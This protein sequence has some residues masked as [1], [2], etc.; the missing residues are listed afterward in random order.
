MPPVP[1]QFE[2]ALSDQAPASS[3]LDA[4]P[5]RRYAE[6]FQ[7]LIEDN[8]FGSYV[9]D[10]GLRVLHASKTALRGFAS[11]TPFIGRDL[12]EALR[13]VWPEPFAS[14][15]L[16]RFQ[17]T[18]TTGEPYVSRGTVEQRADID[19][20]EAYDWR[21][22]RIPLPDETCG[23]VCY[24]YDFSDRFLWEQRLQRSEARLALVQD[25]ARIGW[26]D[27]NVVSGTLEWSEQ[28]KALFELPPDAVMSYARFLSAIHP[29][30]TAQVDA[31]VRRA[32]KGGAPFDVEMRVLLP[33][34]GVRWVA[35]KGQAYRDDSGRTARMSG[36]ALD[37]T[38]RKQAEEDALLADRRKSEFLSVLSHELRNP[39]AA[40]H[41]S[42]QVLEQDGEDEVRAR[43]AR[44]VIRRQLEHLSRL[45]DDLL[46]LTRISRGK[47]VLQR[48]RFDLRELVTRT[49]DDFRTLLGDCG[50]SLHVFLDGG[51][52]CIDGDATRI[53]QV[54]SNLLL[55]ASKFTPRGGT[56]TV[57]LSSGDGEAEVTIRDTGA[58]MEPGTIASMFEP[59]VQA[60]RTLARSKGGLGLGL[61]LVKYL[62]E[63]H[64]GTVEAR[65]DG[66]GR[67]SEFVIRLPLVE[68]RPEPQRTLPVQSASPRLVLLIEDNVDAADSLAELLGIM[69]NQVRVASDGTSGLALARELLPD[70]VVCDIG[71]PDLDGCEIA[72]A[73]R[74]DP[75]LSAVRLVA[76]SGYTQPEE[77][78]RAMRAGFD[79]YLGKPADVRQLVRLFEDDGEESAA[80]G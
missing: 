77:V 39:L 25:A 49:T 59:F 40:L 75:V 66:P 44:G 22:E 18:L 24:F 20:V 38:A 76:L 78:E 43:R 67:G 10:A 70:L 61:P 3:D 57:R 47:V 4:D 1:C 63:L 53:A 16:A 33:H 56:V 52:F 14:E 37:V 50:L 45:V 42:L 8:P 30:D 71:L 35:S 74:E 58:G 5:L 9:V 32:V 34:G 69:G 54:L 23:V 73:F 12:A 6:T 31:A 65:S 79:A 46:D 64:C 72:R 62:T 7:G 19:A 17:H 13:I 11:V 29:E 60:E 36:M 21:L 27:W 68:G 51:S 48:Q 80:G 41:N 15:V 28:C 26:W 55:N 2:V